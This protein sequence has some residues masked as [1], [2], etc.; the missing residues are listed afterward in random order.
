MRPPERQRTGATGYAAPMI[1]I[2][3]LRTIAIAA[4]TACGSGSSPPATARPAAAP[5][6]AP[7]A[8]APAPEQA[9]TPP[10]LRLPAGA[11]P[12]KNAVELTIDPAVED[13]TGAITTD[14][15]ISAPLATLWLDGNEITIDDAK[16]TI[17]AERIAARA[18]TAGKDFIGLIPERPLA[19]GRATLVAH[20][21]IRHRQV[22]GIADVELRARAKP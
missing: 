17:G 8:A 21:Q 16:F 7:A 9:P 12:L 13:F 19:P 3:T 5:P 20:R 1:T 15:E 4:L 18:I 10:T 2:R 11:R 14:L 6:A 22:F